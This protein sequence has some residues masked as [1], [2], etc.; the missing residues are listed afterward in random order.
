MFSLGGGE[1]EGGVG[2]GKMGLT[3]RKEEKGR[4]EGSEGRGRDG[5]GGGGGRVKRD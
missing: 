1:K 2:E 3:G 5:G 4:K